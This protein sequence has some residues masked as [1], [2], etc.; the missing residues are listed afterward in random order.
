MSRGTRCAQTR[1]LCLRF[2]CECISERRVYP[3]ASAPKRVFN[4]EVPSLA[5]MRVIFLNRYFYPSQAPTGILL[6]DLTFALSEEGSSAVVITSRLT[7]EDS[8]TLLP[9]RGT[10]HGVDVYRVWTTRRSRSGLLGR[11]FEYASFFLAAAWRLW[12]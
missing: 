3:L 10:I 2:R 8:N 5:R 4:L 11:S 7:Y 1:G 9:P 12:R 6:S